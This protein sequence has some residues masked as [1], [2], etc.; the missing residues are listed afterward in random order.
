[1]L[2]RFAWHVG[3]LARRRLIRAVA[4]VGLAVFSGFCSTG[5]TAQVLLFSANSGEQ[6]FTGTSYVDFNGTASGGVKLS[7]AT[8]SA[9]QRVSIVFDATCYVQGT[10]AFAVVT[11]LVD[12][13]GSAGE[14]AAPP[15]NNIS[16]NGV[17]FCFQESGN[18]FNNAARASVVASVSPQLA[19]THTVRVRVRIASLTDDPDAKATLQAMSLTVLR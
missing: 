4:G 15:T 9:N 13:A 17:V 8:S 3:R 16:N 14:T 18:V 11:I 19:G 7:F 1:M 5:A 2:F 6:N 12:P 10:E